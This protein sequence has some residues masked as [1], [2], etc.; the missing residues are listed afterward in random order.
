[1]ADLSWTTGWDCV[2][3]YEDQLLPNSYT[4]TVH[5]DITTDNTEE[6]T[7]AFD[8]IKY[9]IDRVLT[10]SIFTCIDDENN[11][12]YHKNYKQKLVTFPVAPQD[13]SVVSALFAKFNAITAG[14][15]NLEKIDLHSTQ[16]GNIVLHFDVDF[17]QESSMLKNH[18][19]IEASGKTVWWFRDDIG[20]ADFFALNEDSKDITMIIDVTD[21]EGTDLEWPDPKDKKLKKDASN[22]NPTIIPGGKTHH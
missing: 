7:I 14:R 6:Q 4:V 18:E 2:L 3:A 22:W 10:D 20:S 11:M 16:G 13:M 12:F 8:R 19:F 17:A 5:F 9:F 1:M 21:W 15:I